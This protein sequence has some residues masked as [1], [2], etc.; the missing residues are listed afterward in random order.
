MTKERKE[1]IFQFNHISKDLDSNTEDELKQLY[2]FYHK[3]FWC[4][5]QAHKI[6]KKRNLIINLCSTS[7]VLLG[8][9]IGAVTANVIILGVV[10]GSGV[11][12]K[13]VY[14]AKNYKQRM[15]FSKF[16]YQNYNKILV[17]IQDYLRGSDLNEDH[18]LLKL[19]HVDDIVIDLCPDISHYNERYDKKFTTV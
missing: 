15:E 10:T 9:I 11:L 2:G 17:E 18:F 16:A 14:E 19:K 3:K 6:W 13:T 12:L 1:R 7:L 8:T 5:G 4:F